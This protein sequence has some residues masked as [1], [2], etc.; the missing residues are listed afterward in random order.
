MK[1]EEKEVP[2]ECS[3]LNRVS[4]VDGVVNLIEYCDVGKEFVIVMERMVPCQNLG[5]IIRAESRAGSLGEQR[6][7]IYFR[8]LVNA[9]VKCYQAGV[10][11][12]DIKVILPLDPTIRILRN[13]CGY[14]R[15]QS[16]KQ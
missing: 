15:F 5:Q 2:L 16:N 10:L 11:R 4:H 1:I 12:R 9:V 14:R 8:Q 7:R 6:A 3:L 13:T